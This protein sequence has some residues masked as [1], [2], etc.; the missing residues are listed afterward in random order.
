M[1]SWCLRTGL[2]VALVLSAVGCSSER[3]P[4]NH[5]QAD[6]LP[7]S[8]FL[9]N[10]LQGTSDDPVFYARAFTVD[11]SIAQETFTAGTYSGTDKI[12]WEITEDHL[13]AR[14][15][16][17]AADGR[18][19]KGLTGGTTTAN[20]TLVA[21]YKITKQFD[22]KRDY[23]ET[24]GELSNV[25]EENDTDRIWNEREYIRVDWSTNEVN[26]PYWGEMFF[27]HLF[28]EMKISPLTYNAN[29]PS[30]VDFSDP[31]NEAPHLEL[32]QGYLDITNHFFVE[33]LEMQFSWGS[34]PT[35]LVDGYFTGTNNYDC[36]AQEAAV[37]FAFWKRPQ[38]DF[39]PMDNTGAH[40]DIIAN[41]GGDGDSIQPGFG[42]PRQT[43]DPQY[44]YTDAGLH[45]LVGKHDIWAASHVP[46]NLVV[47][48]TAFSVCDS[49]ADADND[50]TA[51]QC[52]FVTGMTLNGKQLG[53]GSRCDT[54]K[55]RDYQ[56]VQNA[57]GTTSAV[58]LA[59][60]SSLNAQKGQCTIP[61]R[62]RDTKVV[63]YYNN[64]EFPEKFLDHTDASGQ[65]VAGAAEDIVKSWDQFMRNAVAFARE[66][67]CRRTGDGDRA[68]CHSNFFN[69]DDTPAN[70]VMVSYGGWLTDNP[71]RVA[72]A[73]QADDHI[74]TLCHNPVRPTDDLDNCAPEMPKDQRVG[75]RARVGD[76]RKNFMIH[77]PW[78]ANAHYGGLAGI[79]TDPET[80]EYFGNTATSIYTERR[81]RRI[82]DALL[83]AM[84]DITPQQYIDGVAGQISQTTFAGQLQPGTFNKPKIFT[85]A[86]IA[87]RVDAMSADNLSQ[88]AVPTIAGSNI[89]EKMLSIYEQQA[90]TTNAESLLAL[91]IAKTDAL[92]QPL[93]GS[94]LEANMIADNQLATRLLG[95]APGAALDQGTI[96][97]VS[98]LR[99]LD[100]A[101]LKEIRQTMS[102]RYAQ[103]GACYLEAAGGQSPGVVV[104]ASLANHF[105]QKYGSL[106]PEARAAAMLDELT[107]ES[108]KGVMLHEFGHSLGMHH[109]F[110]SS[111]DS[112]N[113]MPQYWQ[114]RTNEGQA[115]GTCGG[116]VR[117]PEG[118]QGPD[119]ENARN[120][121]SCMGPR[122]LDPETD[123]ELGLANE[124]RPSIDYFAGTTTM[125]YQ[126]ER[127][128]ETAG[129]GTYDQ[130]YIQAAYGKVLETYDNNRTSAADQRKFAGRMFT[131]LT[132]QNLVYDVVTP[133]SGTPL[134]TASY[135]YGG[136][137]T[138]PF[139][140]SWH[141][142]KLARGIGIFDKARDCRPATDEEKRMDAN[143]IQNNWRIVHGEVCAP[144]SRDHA[145]WDDF[146]SDQNPDVGDFEVK[147]H[148]GPNVPTNPNTVRWSYRYGESYESAYIHTNPT[149]S[150]ADEYEVLANE[151]K[152]F[153]ANYL[154]SYFRQGS[155]HYLYEGIAGGVQESYFERVRSYH[156]NH[157]NNALRY[158]T[159][160]TNLYN[161]LKN[162]D[163]WF[164]SAAIANAEAYS[165]LSRAILVPQ[166][167]DYVVDDANNQLYAGRLYTTPSATQQG[168]V[169][170]VFSIDYTNGDGRFVD[171]LFDYS[172]DCGGSYKANLCIERAGYSLERAYAFLALT[173]S[174][175][176]LATISRDN[177]LDGRDP[178][179]NFRSDM[180]EAFDRLFGALLSEDWLSVGMYIPTSDDGGAIN[181]GS[182]AL[183]DLNSGSNAPQ[184]THLVM[185]TDGKV[186]SAPD[187][188]AKVLFPNV[189]Y[190]QQLYAAIFSALYARENTDMTLIHKMRVWVDGDEGNISDQAFPQPA[191]QIRFVDPASGFTY[192]ARRFGTETVDGRTVEKGI[193]SRMLQH[194]NDLLAQAYVTDDNTD[195][196]PKVDS[197]GSPVLKLDAQGQPQLRTPTGGGNFTRYRGVVDSVRELG[198]LLG[199]GPL[200]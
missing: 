154:S 51:D 14:R 69:S 160:G 195:G 78:D 105:K 141:Y 8:F 106:S 46:S 187:T 13:N 89:K 112:M 32:E 123:D 44:G 151:E 57:N 42:T 30:K 26:D 137:G 55:T 100:P 45:E 102:E 175:P 65:P 72:P 38:S 117:I 75:F 157:A 186:T 155:K 145:A 77:W 166:P 171:D 23:N 104:N 135:A 2:G 147:W 10:D 36:N 27:G 150:G 163:N 142:T 74:L 185:G 20:G 56:A 1:K 76:I 139:L 91:G 134:D 96:D 43:W 93:L 191:D 111:Y 161:Q 114:L 119:L 58:P 5:V 48:G 120:T 83:V 101:K 88:A 11:H 28:G 33:P 113:Y 81:A 99:A 7:K 115:S 197:F 138:Q 192:I 52:A 21:S 47:G 34:L 152:Y 198:T 126:S 129:L 169:Q 174:R 177:Y 97:Q 159:F 199:N 80:M 86:E 24:T 148:T 70:K 168:T 67:E 40:R 127:F 66:V 54:L 107:V 182:P 82:L 196:T 188:D 156:W 16:Y 60:V 118:L 172:G 15:A 158:L 116:S 130:H 25:T 183:I 49:D 110:A 59:Q 103:R 29:D 64:K 94:N 79:F 39:E 179:L 73:A 146:V 50:G 193:G 149:D 68:T 3:A 4:I 176:T 165:A 184:R 63:A 173:D 22:I 35:C 136:F 53:K 12:R 128:S 121:D 131:Q 167:G 170:P 6:A 31:D 125:E 124:S 17:Q 189:G 19:D 92:A 62:D 190:I 140:H 90:M 61:Y 87:K 98:P 9:G 71:K 108:F 95:L 162:D 144:P 84:G 164:R 194:A 109:Q 178:A 85:N 41:F 37:R 153:N 18:D 181:S 122:Y 143:G 200:D 132:E 180:P 133:D